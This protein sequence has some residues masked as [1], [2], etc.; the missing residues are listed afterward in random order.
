MAKV[1]E[2]SPDFDP[3]EKAV[4]GLI[5]QGLSNKELKGANKIKC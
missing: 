5:V 2:C 3:W 4:K 1:R